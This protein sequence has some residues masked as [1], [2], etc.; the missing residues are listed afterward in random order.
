[1]TA[2]RPRVEPVPA[3]FPAE[4]QA[5]FDGIMPPGVPPFML[6]CLPSEWA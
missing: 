1:M 5:V 2:T 4:V 6:H 3:P